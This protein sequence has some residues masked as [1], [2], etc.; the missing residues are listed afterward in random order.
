MAFEIP[1][2]GLPAGFL[3][4]MA[5]I[6]MAKQVVW[7]VKYLVEAWKAYQEGR[8]AKIEAKERE[9]AFEEYLRRTRRRRNKRVAKN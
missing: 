6:W 1:V 4:L 2:V 8:E 3:V 7:M 9:R 5:V